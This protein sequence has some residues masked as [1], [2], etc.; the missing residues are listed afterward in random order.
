M[1][2]FSPCQRW[3]SVHFVILS[4]GFVILSPQRSISCS[5]SQRDARLLFITS[6]WT[7]LDNPSSKPEQALSNRGRERKAGMFST[8]NLNQSVFGSLI[9]GQTTEMVWSSES[10]DRRWCCCSPVL[11]K[12]VEAHLWPIEAP[13]F[14]FLLW[15]LTRRLLSQSLFYIIF[16]FHPCLYIWSIVWNLHLNRKGGEGG[17]SVFFTPFHFQITTKTGSIWA[18]TNIWPG[19]VHISL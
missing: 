18:A 13:P 17:L 9:F 10:S 3:F 19:K 6:T 5:S 4:I 2:T 15:L 11:W 14:P 16:W 7:P 12:P 1:M 8:K